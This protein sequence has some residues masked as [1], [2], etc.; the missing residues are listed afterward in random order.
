MMMEKPWPLV[1]AASGDNTSYSDQA[2][3]LPPPPTEGISA[4]P[5]RTHKLEEHQREWT[6]II[7]DAVLILLP[8]GLLAKAI[9][10][11]IFGDQGHLGPGIGLDLVPSTTK[12]LVEFNAQLVTL[13]TIIFTT[14]VATLVR[15]YALWKAQKGAR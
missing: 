8:L 15:R 5:Q 3:A 2:P 11:A 6:V 12:R 4:W 10:V 7:Y 1:H 13:F 14:I 9:L